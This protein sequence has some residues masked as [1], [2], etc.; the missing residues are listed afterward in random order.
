MTGKA[1]AVSFFFRLKYMCARAPSSVQSEDLLNQLQC[2]LADGIVRRQL[3]L[4]AGQL[5]KVPAGK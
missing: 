5:R 3:L 4:S 1:H 2:G